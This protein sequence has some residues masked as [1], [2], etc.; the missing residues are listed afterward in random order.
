VAAAE[1]PPLLSVWLDEH[2]TAQAITMAKQ[3][4]LSSDRLIMNRR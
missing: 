2:A 3:I 4:G 1:V